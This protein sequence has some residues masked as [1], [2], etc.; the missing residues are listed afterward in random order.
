MEMLLFIYIYIHT[1]TQLY[2]FI[3]F[4]EQNYEKKHLLILTLSSNFLG[5]Y[6][7]F[8]ENLSLWL[9]TLYPQ[10]FSAYC[11]GMKKTI[12]KTFCKGRR[13]KESL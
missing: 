9:Y 8:I 4:K 6:F 12:L 11:C 5:F 2:I 10:S 3:F 1:Y 7:Y 13:K